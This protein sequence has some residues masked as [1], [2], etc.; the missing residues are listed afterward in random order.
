MDVP[1][2]NQEVLESSATGSAFRGRG[3]IFSRAGVPGISNFEGFRPETTTRV[4]LR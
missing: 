2:T 4:D 1:A 3:G